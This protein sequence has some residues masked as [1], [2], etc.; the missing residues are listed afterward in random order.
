MAYGVG[1]LSYQWRHNGLPLT[2]DA[3]ITGVNTPALTINSARYDDEGPY[4]CVVTDNCGP[5]TSSAATLTLPTPNWVLRTDIVHAPKRAWAGFA[6]DS[7]RGV[8]VL[9]GGFQ[10]GN[11]ATTYHDHWEYDGVEWVQRTPPQNPGGR[12]QHAMVYDSDRKRIYLF[13]GL[14]T[15]LNEP[16]SDLWEFDGTTW[17]LRKPQTDP[18]SPPTWVSYAARLPIAYDSIRKKVV[19]V[20]AVYGQTNDSKTWEYDPAA[21]TWSERLASNGFAGADWDTMAFDPVQGKVVRYYTYNTNDAQTWRWDGN[22]WVKDPAINQHQYQSEMAYDNVRRRLILFFCFINSTMSRPETWYD[23]NPNW[24][25]QLAAGPPTG[26]PNDTGFQRMV[27]DSRRRAMV[28]LTYKLFPAPFDGPFDVY[29]Y[30]Y[31]DR[32]VFDRQPASQPFTP[33][34]TATFKVYAA[35]YGTLTYQWKRN[36]QDIAD[37]PSP[38]GGAFSG[39]TTPMLTLTGTQATDEAAYACMVSNACGNALSGAAR[40]GS[41]PGDCDGDFDVD[42]DDVNAF[43]ACTWRRRADGAELH[44]SG[45]RS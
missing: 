34:G 5:V 32:V 25:L 3:R 17:I 24:A 9:Y 36:G 42:L 19:L 38:G 21:N 45:S 15:D 7:D 2:N 31:L 41:P 39:A 37:G 1:P 29:E 28:A 26:P 13:G 30:R 12:R 10:S 33:G 4:D 20:T 11:P 35:G 14:N 44:L 43:R 27:Y 18:D 22:V 40:L 6:Y 23:T 16:K 8:G